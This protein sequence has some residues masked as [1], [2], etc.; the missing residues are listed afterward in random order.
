[1]H[2]PDNVRLPNVEP[3]IKILVINLGYG[4]KTRLQDSKELSSLIK[5]GYR[6]V[7]SGGV[8]GGGTEYGLVVIL[9][10]G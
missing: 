4:T 10:K 1:M 2:L 6:I 9:Q 8:G 7:S 5:D 3:S